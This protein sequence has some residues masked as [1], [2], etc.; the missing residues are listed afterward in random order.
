MLRTSALGLFLVAALASCGGGGGSGP[1]PE[2]LPILGVGMARIDRSPDQPLGGF[3][4]FFYDP[5]SRRLL[6]AEARVDTLRIDQSFAPGIVP[7]PIYVFPGGVRF[8]ESYRLTATVQTL[9]GPVT[10]SSAD[11]VVPGRFTVTGPAQHPR[12]QP[13]AVQWDPITNAQAIHVAVTGTAFEAELPGTATGFT[14]PATALAN[15]TSAEVEVT[16]YNSFYVS[17]NIG[18]STLNDAEE[19]V[20]RFSQAENIT[21]GGIR[22]SFGA[23]VT[24]GIIVTLQ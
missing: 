10:V 1:D 14:I 11:V 16:A 4:V 2:D 15:L 18:I 5:N 23:A 13:L 24:Q 3:I 8:E 17:L 21:G 6:T 22:G 12:N 9:E 19:A 20:R 7:G